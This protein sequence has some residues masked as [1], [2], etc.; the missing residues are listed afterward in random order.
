M[1]GIKRPVAQASEPQGDR[2]YDKIMALLKSK[3][4]AGAMNYELNRIAFRYVARI[5]DM[6]K[7]GWNITTERVKQGVYKFTLHE[8]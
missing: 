2:Q 6:R 8:D 3:G 5:H 1:F 7:D 4:E